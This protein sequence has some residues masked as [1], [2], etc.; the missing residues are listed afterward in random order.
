MQQ[1]QAVVLSDTC[2]PLEADNTVNPPKLNL[3]QRFLRIACPVEGQLL[4]TPNFIQKY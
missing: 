4:K 2:R 1:R 3:S